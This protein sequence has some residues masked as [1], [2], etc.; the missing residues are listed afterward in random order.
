MRCG[1]PHDLRHMRFVFWLTLAEVR[2]P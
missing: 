1:R 2:T